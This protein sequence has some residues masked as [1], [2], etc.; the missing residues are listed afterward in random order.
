MLAVN[1]ES[2]LTDPINW[3][4]VA[5]RLTE[6]SQHV[7][8]P[9][10]TDARFR[11]RRAPLHQARVSPLNPFSLHMKR[12]GDSLYSFHKPASTP[13][14]KKQLRRSRLPPAAIVSLANMNKHKFSLAAL[15]ILPNQL[16]KLFG[17]PT[18]DYETALARLRCT[19]FWEGTESGR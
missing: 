10:T 11:E 8:I 15:G 3:S 12:D 6:W 5:A 1:K 7:R 16:R 14:D 19:F 2:I 9:E 4:L 17:Q 13:V 18:S